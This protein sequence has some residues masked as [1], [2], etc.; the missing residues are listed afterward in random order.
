[1]KRQ[2][3]DVTKHPVL[4]IDNLMDAGLRMACFKFSYQFKP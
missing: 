3:F 2:L 1:M 4:G